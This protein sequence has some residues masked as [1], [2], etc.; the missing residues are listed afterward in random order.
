M[1]V[2]LALGGAGTLHGEFRW[3]YGSPMVE[4]RAVDEVEFISMKDPSIVRDGD[5][6]HLFCTVRGPGKSSLDCLKELVE[7]PA[8][9]GDC[10][11]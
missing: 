7:D 5:K 10:G 11:G 1:I 8:Y 9:R 6:W 2:G 3:S 4:A